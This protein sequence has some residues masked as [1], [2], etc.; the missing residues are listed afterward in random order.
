MTMNEFWKELKSNPSLSADACEIVTKKVAAIE[1]EEAEKTAMNAELRAAALNILTDATEPVTASAV[2]D[3]LDITTSK[4]TNVLK[5]IDG[6][7]VSKVIVGNRVVNG[8]SL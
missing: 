2:A 7:K 8:Y 4:A 1:A 3:E 6:V 5:A